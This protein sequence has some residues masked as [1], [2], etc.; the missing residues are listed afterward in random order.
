M[1]ASKV[2]SAARLANGKVPR[3]MRRLSADAVVSARS[4]SKVGVSTA[5]VSSSRSD[6]GSEAS[7]GRSAVGQSRVAACSL[8]EGNERCVR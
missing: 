6:D 2:E 5:P 3:L 4:S 8:R 1:E 7:A